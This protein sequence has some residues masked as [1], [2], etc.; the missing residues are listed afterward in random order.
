MRAFGASLGFLSVPK[1]Q[2]CYTQ[3]THFLEL[4]LTGGLGDDTDRVGAAPGSV[5]HPGGSELG[6]P[7]LPLGLTG[8]DSLG[9]TSPSFCLL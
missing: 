4:P 3:G 1:D 9:T 5:A 8:L 7:G 2:F 6:S